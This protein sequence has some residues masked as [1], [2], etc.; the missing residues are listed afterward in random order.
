M[1]LKEGSNVLTSNLVY[2]SGCYCLT[3]ACSIGCDF[4]PGPTSPPAPKSAER[5]V[6]FFLPVKEFTLEP[7]WEKWVDESQ[8]FVSKQKNHSTKIY[9]EIKNHPD[10]Y[11]FV[12]IDK[13][14]GESFRLIEFH[15][16]P[17]PETKDMAVAFAY[18]DRRNAARDKYQGRVD[19]LKT[20]LDLITFSRIYEKVL[21]PQTRFTMRKH[22][23]SFDIWN[24]GGGW[25]GGESRHWTSSTF[26]IGYSDC[27]IDGLKFMESSSE[28]EAMI[29]DDDL[30]LLVSTTRQ[31]NELFNFK[32]F[33]YA[34]LSNKQEIK[35]KRLQT[36]TVRS[37]NLNPHYR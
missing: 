36:V 10:H 13:I 16:E 6:V 21:K 37:P 19:S 34:D 4:A 30:T 25:F 31:E 18:S 3:I 33:W 8:F 32:Q 9:L 28:A 26:S 35:P 14:Y 20:K 12:E 17:C 5:R 7:K 23:H 24:A 1:Q 27:F 2:L 29:S 22:F 11:A 15:S